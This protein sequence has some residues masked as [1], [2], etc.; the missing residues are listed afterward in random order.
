MGN[1][2]KR[3]PILLVA[4]AGGG[5]RE[6]VLEGNEVFLKNKPPSP[7]LRMKKR[8]VLA[9]QMAGDERSNLPIALLWPDSHP[10]FLF[11][12]FGVSLLKSVPVAR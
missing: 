7:R 9:V 4:G 8:G 6:A 11:L 5:R 10:L 12:P 1:L 3:N 2:K